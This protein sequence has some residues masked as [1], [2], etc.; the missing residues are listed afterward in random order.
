MFYHHTKER[1]SLRGWLHYGKHSSLSSHFELSWRSHH[2]LASVGYE[3]EGGWG[4]CLAFAPIFFSVGV[5]LPRFLSLRNSREV[6]VS[7]HGGTI[8][9]S[10]WSDPWGD[11]RKLS[12][13]RHGNFAF[14]DFLLGRPV[15]SEKVLEKREV[16]VPM[17]EKSYS[18]TAE[19][20]EA[21]WT[22]PRWFAR[23][24]KRCKI[25]VPEGIPHAGK[26]E[27]SW[28]CGDDATFGL[29]TAARSITDGVGILV[30]HCLSDRVRY[31]GWSDYSWPRKAKTI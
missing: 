21:T 11:D 28:D 13:L 30:G 15:Y 26:G 24:I 2:F 5:E 14:V 9:W 25:D 29:T 3:D 31:G 18:A 6:K 23:T 4:L 17:P 1:G 7:I 19:L 10:I 22:R 8:W 27:N 16:V 12:R 20:L